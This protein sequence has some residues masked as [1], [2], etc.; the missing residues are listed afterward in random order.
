[1]NMSVFSTQM[2]HDLDI[3]KRRLREVKTSDGKSCYDMMGETGFNRRFNPM[4]PLMWLNLAQ[5][6]SMLV[7]DGPNL[8]ASKAGESGCLNDYPKTVT[9]TGGQCSGFGSPMDALAKSLKE[10]SDE[11]YKG[12]SLSSSCTYSTLAAGRGCM[13]SYDLPMLSPNSKIKIAMDTCPSG[14]PFF[15]AYWSHPAG[16]GGFTDMLKPCDEDTECGGGKCISLVDNYTNDDVFDVL[17][18]M[19]LVTNKADVDNGDYHAVI[20]KM[21]DIFRMS[22]F[23]AGPAI[24]SKMALCIPQKPDTDDEQKTPFKDCEK[25]SD[26]VYSCR[27]LESW[28]GKINN[29][30]NVMDAKVEGLTL[31][32]SPAYQA[33]KGMRMLLSHSCDGT[34][35]VSLNDDIGFSFRAPVGRQGFSALNSFMMWLQK[36]RSRN[37]GQE[38]TDKQYTSRFQAWQAPWW[39]S[40]LQKDPVKD[41]GIEFDDWRIFE[42]GKILDWHYR[43]NIPS[44]CSF[45]R[46]ISGQSCDLKYD[47]KDLFST[48]ADLHFSIRACPDSPGGLPEF[49]IG[50][51]SQV[52]G[53]VFNPIKECQVAADCGTGYVCEDFVAVPFEMKKHSEITNHDDWIAKFLFGCN[54]A[55]VQ[56]YSQFSGSD[57]ISMDF[58]R[59]MQQMCG[60]APT[61]TATS[62]FCRPDDSAMAMDWDK[63]FNYTQTW[64]FPVQGE[65]KTKNQSPYA[66]RSHSQQACHGGQK[67]G[68]CEGGCNADDDCEGN[69]Q[70][71]PRNIAAGVCTA[72]G[73]ADIPQQSYCLEGDIVS[74]MTNM[75]AS[76]VSALSPP[77]PAPTPPPGTQVTTI[78]AAVTLKG[79]TAEEFT[80]AVQT[81][82]KKTIAIGVGSGVTTDDVKI[83]NAPGRRTGLNVEFEITLRD[84][85]TT[86]TT[87][88]LAPLANPN[89]D[90]RVKALNNFLASDSQT[91]FVKTM[92]QVAEI[93]GTNSFAQKV[94]SV[95]VTKSAA[96][97]TTTVGVPP[98]PSSSSSSSVLL[99]VIVSAV[100][101]VVVIGAA[102]GLCFICKSTTSAMPQT[103]IKMDQCVTA[104]TDEVGV[105]MPQSM[106]GKDK[107]SCCQPAM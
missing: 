20:K 45:E 34:L 25:G 83:L 90:G 41:Q 51:V 16:E 6:S 74:A 15:S 5:K 88:T 46:V 84:L 22:L 55:D 98:P 70:C 100:G 94:N 89:A 59:N 66:S 79:V 39:V 7:Y 28:D 3:M 48:P 42:K 105:T 14:T 106:E 73:K 72:G 33:S 26:G 19:N 107:E 36:M 101:A 104:E 37:L 30:M 60:A 53:D 58:K 102:V 80:P 96:A 1:M 47:L 91:G 21:K 64:L 13:L 11:D 69:F 27:K 57:R 76:T 75:Q 95:T 52:Y 23:S 61:A 17:K 35:S 65:F 12:A 9:E 40:Q 93:D 32:V 67:C 85:S 50:Y 49:G 103:D 99:I 4:S 78:R 77:P 86:S 8:N 18:G 38:L 44:T 10:V 54:A 31:P 92:K 63:A 24:G 56:P 2:K 97:K 29:N 82:F 87:N 81:T 68:N 62:K 71:V 43:F